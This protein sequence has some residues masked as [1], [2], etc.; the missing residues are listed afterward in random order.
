MVPPK[1]SA[2]LYVRLDLAKQTF[3]TSYKHTRNL[4]VSTFP[5]QPNII[6][7]RRGSPTNKSS[8]TNNLI[9]RFGDHSRQLAFKTLICQGFAP[10]AGPFGGCWLLGCCLASFVIDFAACWLVELLLLGFRFTNFFSAI[11][12]GSLGSGC[13]FL[14]RFGMP[15]RSLRL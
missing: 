15:R 14:C 5:I 2:T 1:C 7:R 3:S 10:A 11:R 13:T 9:S 4:I 6:R 12:V 8:L